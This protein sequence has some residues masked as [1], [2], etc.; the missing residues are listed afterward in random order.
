MSINKLFLLCLGAC[1]WQTASLWAQGCSDAGFCTLGDIKHLNNSVLSSTDRA[2]KLTFSVANGLGE[3]GVFVLTPSLQ[4]DRK[5][6]DQW[7]VQAKLTTG[8]ASGDLG[9]AFGL[10]DFFL[11][12]TYRK[13]GAWN[14]SITLGTKLP[15]NKANLTEGARALPMPYQSSLGTVDAIVGLSVANDHWKFALAYQQP[16]SGTNSNTFL[17]EYWTDTPEAIGY[18]PTN[19][20]DRKGD[21]LLR[22]GHSWR[23]GEKWDINLGLLA[24]Y[25]LGDDAYSDASLGN[26]AIVLSNSKGLTLNANASAWYRASDNLSVGLVIGAPFVVRETRPDGLTRAFSIAPELIV[27]F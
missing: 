3:Q 10:G 22:A 18:L 17:H 25:H 15:L 21:L 5:L 27:H 11:A 2:D 19:H 16:L 20:F 7:A 6:T 8:Y 13:Q 12:A 26:S 14:H 4:Y 23:T 9:S 24:I 1:L